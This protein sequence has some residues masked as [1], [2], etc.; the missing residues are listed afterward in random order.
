MI[1]I[2]P[3]ICE[4]ASVCVYQDK[5]R[6]R[7]GSGVSPADMSWAAFLFGAMVIPEGGVTPRG[8]IPPSQC[9]RTCVLARS[10]MHEHATV[11]SPTP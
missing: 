4:V 6:D 5:A 3:C 9:P 8:I 2:K 11:T 7:P 10:Q 1:Q